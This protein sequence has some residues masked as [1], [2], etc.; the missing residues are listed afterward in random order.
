[1]PSDG[2]PHQVAAEE[3]L[4]EVASEVEKKRWESVP[5]AKAHTAEQVRTWPLLCPSDGPRN[6]LAI[7]DDPLMSL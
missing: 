2:V 1:M 7:T 3:K 6:G 4:L 5:E